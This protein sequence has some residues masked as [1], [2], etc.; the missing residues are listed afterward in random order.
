M[1]SSLTKNNMS[2]QPATQLTAPEPPIVKQNNTKSTLLVVFSALTPV[3]LLITVVSGLLG[4]AYDTA[5]VEPNAFQSVAAVIFTIALYGAMSIGF[6]LAIASLTISIVN[7]KKQQSTLR[8][9]NI[10]FICIIN[11]LPIIA[12]VFGIL[13]IPPSAH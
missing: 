5:H 8:K 4:L 3:P 13:S 6:I 7:F 11:A 1:V 2:E 12:W 10:I 9:I